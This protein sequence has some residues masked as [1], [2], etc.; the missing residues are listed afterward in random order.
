MPFIELQSVDSTNKYA[1]GLAHAGMA[2]HGMTIF[3]YEQTAGR[4]QRS[5]E[6]LSE[7]GRNL[8]FS[9]VAKPYPL[10]TTQVFGMSIITALAVHEIFQ[11]FAGEETRIK[12]PNDIYWRDRKAGGI[13]IENIVGSW[14]SG[15][16]S[17]ES[18]VGNW[19]WSVIGI[20]LN[21]NQTEFSPD[22]PNP[23]SLKQITGK[24]SNPLVIAKEICELLSNYYQRLVNG[25]YK[26]LLNIYNQR[27]YKIDQSV[28]LKQLSRV[29][30]A[31]IKGVSETGS[32]ITQT[33]MEERFE[34]GEV[35][36]LK[37]D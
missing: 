23:V 29:F 21:I 10:N 37:N 6:W 36:M 13:L 9:I 4:G 16:G 24:E 20:G 1:M 3:A 8:T 25:E 15:V 27:L 18:G 22:L 28:K 34:F 19:K 30:T 26:E 31:I 12:W 14:E 33:T 35:E 11:R 17:E 32:L 5:K 7:K 2:T